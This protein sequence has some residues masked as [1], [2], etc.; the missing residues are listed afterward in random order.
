MLTPKEFSSQKFD[1]VL[2]WGYDMAQ[3]DSFF[4]RAEADYAALYQE[5]SSLN[6]QVKELSEKTAEPS[7]DFESEVK[8]F[9]AE[10]TSENPSSDASEDNSPVEV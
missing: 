10:K 9:P 7:E 8:I 1:K 3:V 2:M 6:A 5:N 4:E